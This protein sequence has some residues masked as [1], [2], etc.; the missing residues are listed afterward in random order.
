MD[1]MV[2]LIPNLEAEPGTFGAANPTLLLP[3]DENFAADSDVLTQLMND[4]VPVIEWTRHQRRPLEEEW[5]AIRRME[6]LVHD[7]NRRYKGRLDTYLPVYSRI[8]GTLISSLSRGLFPS[9]E[10]MD[11]VDRD[12]MNDQN[13][14]ATKHYLQWEFE[15]N[16][17]LRANVKPFLRQFVNYGTG[18][19]KYWYRKEERKE[20]RLSLQGAMQKFLMPTH[21]KYANDGLTVSAR[22]LLNFYIYPLTA[23]SLAEC[24]LVFED[25]DVPRKTVLA[26]VANKLWINGDEALAGARPSNY[27]S[28]QN[29]LF[30]DGA[31]TSP[32]HDALGRSPVGDIRVITEVWTYLSLPRRAYLQDEVPGTPVPVKITLAGHVPM[33]VRRIQTYSQKPPYL[34][35]RQNADSGLFY[36]YGAGRQVRQLQYLINDFSNQTADCGAYSL[37]PIVKVNPGLLAGPLRPLAPGVVWPMTDVNQGA[38]FDRPDIELVNYGLGMVNQFIGMAQNFSGA[39]PVLQ[40]T[41]GAG[42]ATATQILQHN[43]TQPLQDTV[44][45][46]E[47]DVLVELMHGAWLLAQQYRDQEVIAM[48]AGQPITITPE[49][50]VLNPEMRWLASSQA[51]NQQQRAQQAISLMQSVAPLVPL[52]MQQ[53]YVVDFASLI[54]KVYSDGFGFRG[55]DQF[56]YKAQAMPGGPMFGQPMPSGVQAEQGDRVRSALEQVAGEG[57]EMAPGEGGAFGEVRAN[58]D[59]LAAMMG[60]GGNPTGE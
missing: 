30:S 38:V 23:G 14:K 19:I 28:N 16:A 5:N 26:K 58:A 6:L 15:T 59:D 29:E 17:R 2:P 44:E 56:I 7:E 31:N 50:L 49:M 46:I 55:F 40:G 4:I 41:K 21:A 51:A 42:T 34:V 1:Q 35:A 48:V 11:V 12:G 53:G 9:D 45:D 33:E 24:T 57:V 54:Q 25:I 10:Y 32:T 47:L 60:G 13:A 20:V 3:P 43:A 36:G 27:I 52:L 8:L 18:V 37:N 39:P 22:N